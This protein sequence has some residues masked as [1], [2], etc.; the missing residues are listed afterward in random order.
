MGIQSL[1]KILKDYIEPFNESELSGKTIAIDSSIL[2]YKYRYFYQT[3]DFHIKGFTQKVQEFKKL[4]VKPIFVFDGTPPQE[5]RETL[6]SR[7]INRDKS[8][9]R[10]E[11]LNK[12]YSEIGHLIDSDNDDENQRLSE[13]TLELKKIKK[14]LLIVTR[15]HSLEV[16]ELLKDLGVDFIQSLGESEEHCAYLQMNGFADFILTEDTDALAF[17]G[18]NVIFNQKGSYQIIKLETIL[19]GLELSYESFV[20]LCI[21]LGCDFCCKIPKIGPVTGLAIIQKYKSID[22][23][24]KENVKYQVPDSFIY[25]NARAIFLKNKIN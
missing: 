24:L 18:S 20:D 17:G 13:I 23:F 6:E 1:K 5:K 8:I 3:D 11:T 7:T 21:L 19:R 25:E 2:L 15:Q 22:S 10:I 4:G 14:N 9:Q 16:M 12:E